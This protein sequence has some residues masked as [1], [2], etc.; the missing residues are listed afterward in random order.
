MLPCR[1]RG[2]PVYPTKQLQMVLCAFVEV[3]VINTALSSVNLILYTK[4][5]TYKSKVQLRR[6]I[7]CLVYFCTPLLPRVLSAVT[8]QRMTSAYESVC[9]YAPMRSHT[10]IYVRGTLGIRRVC[11]KYADIRRCTLCYTQCEMKFLDMFK[12]HQRMRAYSLYVTHT[13]DIR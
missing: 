12:I 5:N 8:L 4:W 13:L 2:L 6:I 9:S 10:Q 1:L 11:S 7:P 3:K